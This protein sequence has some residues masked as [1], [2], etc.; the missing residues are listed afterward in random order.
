MLVKEIINESSITNFLN[1]K[2]FGQ[3]N[4][5]QKLNKK[6]RKKDGVFLTNSLDTVGNL[7]DIIKIDSEIF[8]K[9][10]LEPSCGQGIFILK[11][12]SDIYLKFPD[13]ILISKFISNNVFFVDIQEDMVEKTRNNISELYNFLFNTEY[14]GTYNGI[15]WDF[16][17]KVSSRLSLFDE[18]KTTPFTDLYNS[19]DYVIGNPPYVTLYGRRDKKENVCFHNCFHI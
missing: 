2:T 7:L 16:T 5:E 12:I 6:E 10:I 3:N 9:R 4:Y 8:S 14:S 18:I 15:T 11:L 19:F 1:Q 17:D 13:S